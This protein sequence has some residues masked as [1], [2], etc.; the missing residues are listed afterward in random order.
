[1]SNRDSWFAEFD[2][3]V[4]RLCKSITA[5]MP[6]NDWL[7][8]VESHPFR[9]VVLESKQAGKYLSVQLPSNYYTQLPVNLARTIA[10]DI[11][12]RLKSESSGATSSPASTTPS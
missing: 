1:M 2:S 7:C 11:V 3:E 4:V 12:N 6:Q 8:R 9:T 5:G 10:D